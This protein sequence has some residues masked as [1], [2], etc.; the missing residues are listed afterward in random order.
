MQSLSLNLQNR[1]SDGDPLPTVIQ[2]LED[3]KVRFRRGQLSLIAAAPGGGK[4]SLAT[5]IAV[6]M[7]YSS[8]EGVPCLYVSA[9][10][11]MSTVASSVLASIMDITLEEAEYMIGQADPDVHDALNDVVNHIWWAFKPSPTLED[12]Q[13]D[14]A[15]YAFVMG[16]YPHLIVVDNLLDINEPGE[17]Y[18]RYNAIIPVLVEVA[19]DTHSHVMLLHH[20][21]GAY[22][23]NNLPVP[24]SAIKSKVSEKPTLVLTLYQPQEG[25]MGIRCVK[26]RN[27][28][29]DTKAGF[30]I[31]LPWLP[32][33][34]Y[35]GV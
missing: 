18:S 29:S 4:S 23:D 2:A 12:I 26:N 14:V 7:A 9:D 19:R 24:R 6:N 20:V 16:D 11:D 5:Y 32:E 8:D 15:A 17:E 25:V 35:F 33:R 34:G 13:N 10:T 30:G 28:P 21:V 22:Q 27:G 31:D 3:I 1:K